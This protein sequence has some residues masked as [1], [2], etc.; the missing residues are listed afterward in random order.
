ML[1]DINTNNDIIEDFIKLIEKESNKLYKKEEF[2]KDITDI[3]DITEI[4]KE[5]DNSI[6]LD[7]EIEKSIELKIDEI[8]DIKKEDTNDNQIILKNKIIKFLKL[9]IN[10]DCQYI[11]LDISKSLLLNPIPDIINNLSPSYIYYKDINHCICY[12]SFLLPIGTDNIIN[13]YYTQKEYDDI[14]L[15]PLTKLECDNIVNLIQMLLYTGISKRN[16]FK[17]L[18]KLFKIRK[19]LKSKLESILLTTDLSISFLNQIKGNAVIFDFE[20]LFIDNKLKINVEHSEKNILTMKSIIYRLFKGN[21]YVKEKFL[22]DTNKFNNNNIDSNFCIQNNIKD[23]PNLKGFDY[24]N[25]KEIYI[26]DLIYN[27]ELDKWI[28]NISNLTT[29]LLIERAK[30]LTDELNN[31]SIGDK[32]GYYYLHIICN[33]SLIELLKSKIKLFKNFIKDNEILDSMNE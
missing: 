33:F 32:K 2:K 25:N 1:F 26:F 22:I 12:S 27:N 29:S 18:D 8:K 6:K 14:K 4:D 23:F 16:W 10:S 5:I 9:N 31:F 15:N 3:T 19:E 24:I 7:N 11:S 30:K 17:P 21:S 20:L 13:N 28:D